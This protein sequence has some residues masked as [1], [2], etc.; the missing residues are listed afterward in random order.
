MLKSTKENKTSAVEKD[1]VEKPV[2][3]RLN[4]YQEMHLDGL[5]DVYAPI[6]QE[7]GEP[8]PSLSVQWKEDARRR[9]GKSIGNR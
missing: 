9:Y 7:Q 6:P 2:D 5:I 8:L 3:R 4:K 1:S